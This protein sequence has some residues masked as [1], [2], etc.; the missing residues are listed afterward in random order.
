[1][2]LKFSSMDE[3]LYKMD[4]MDKFIQGIVKDSLVKNSLA[5]KVKDEPNF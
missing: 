1:M 2:I 4:N 3:M 5:F